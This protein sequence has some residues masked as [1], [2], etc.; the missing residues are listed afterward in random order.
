MK[1]YAKSIAIL[2]LAALLTLCFV[3]CGKNDAP[4]VNG[5]TY[6][7]VSCTVDGEDATETVKALY[8]EQSFSFKK[9]GTCVQTLVWAGEMAELLGTDP[10]EV[11]GTYTEKDKVVTATFSSDEGDVVMTFTLDGDTLTMNDE[12]SVMVYKVK[13][14]S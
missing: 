12:G 8:S 11:N 3:A 5:N 14:N 2:L 13:A 1:T 10:V 6:T 4:S 7:F 9:D